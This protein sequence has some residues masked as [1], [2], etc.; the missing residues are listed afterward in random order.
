MVIAIIGMVTALPVAAQDT[1][2]ESEGRAIVNGLASSFAVPVRE[3]FVKKHDSE[4]RNLTVGFAGTFGVDGPLTAPSVAGH[5][6]SLQWSDA[7]AS[8]SVK[9]TPLG[10]WFAAATAYRYLNASN[11]RP[12]SPDFTYVFG[13]DDWH[14]Y[15]LSLVYAN[16]GGNRFDPS[17]AS[18]G[19]RTEVS[20]GGLTLG[21]KLPL[22]RRLDRAMAITSS[23]GTGL[24]VNYTWVPRFSNAS[25][26]QE[27]WKQKAGLSAKY[28][29]Y[30]WLYATTTLY[31][32]PHAS[33]QQPWDPDFT[34]GF[35]YA[36]WH[37]RTISI[38]FNNYAGNRYP[39]RQ[40]PRARFRDGSVSVS[41]SWSSGQ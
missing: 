14:P 28:S 22:P 41:W 9:Y 16:Y 20:E 36:N 7:R 10:Y 8:A 35:G 2:T 1:P 23:G 33:Q 31:Y 24:S 39:W 34:Y 27:R 15:T 6:A 12:W 4:W 29:I 38:Q 40:G 11:Q 3:L 21:W 25:G 5:P 37:A 32:Y 26:H 19:Q 18:R 30:K 17:R 13:Y